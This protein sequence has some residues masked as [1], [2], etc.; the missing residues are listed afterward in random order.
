MNSKFIYWCAFI[1]LVFL[2]LPVTTLA[3]DNPVGV[4][5]RGHIQDVGDYPADGS[6]VDSPAI[7]GTEG[8]S[9]RIEGFEIKLTGE[10]PAGMEMRYNVHVQNKG[11]LYDENDSA[12][13]PKDGDYAGTRGESLRI[14]A[15]KIVLTDS[16]GKPVPG[17]SVQ[18][19]GHVQNVGDLPADESQWIKDGD[20]LGTVGSSLRLEALLVKV[21]KNQT[22]LTAYQALLT[23]IGK[24]AETDYTAASWGT[25]QKALTDNAVTAD[26]SQL[27]VNKAT[28]A[29]QKAVDGLAKKAAAVVYDTAGTY[30]PET[31]TEVIDGDV[32]VKADGITLRNLHINGDLTIGADQVAEKTEESAADTIN[33]DQITQETTGSIT[34]ELENLYI[35]YFTR[36]SAGTGVGISGSP[37]QAFSF[38]L[39]GG[40]QFTATT[41]GGGT[42]TGAPMQITAGSSGGSP[43]GV[44]IGGAIGSLSLQTPGTQLSLAPGCQVQLLSLQSGALNCGI[45][46]PPTA[47]IQSAVVQAPGAI[48]SGPG[49]IQHADIRANGAIFATRP[50]AFTVAPGV[51]AQPSMPAPPNSGGDGGGGGYTPT[52]SQPVISP[53]G[54]VAFP[55]TVTISSQ[56][57]DAIYYTT[58]GSN[59]T[60]AGAQNTTKVVGG[61]AE[62][63]VTSNI[64]LKVVA[65]RSGYYDSA[66]ASATFT[67][68]AS[69]DLTGI[70]LSTTT[71]NFTFTP[72]TY[73]YPS[74]TVPYDTQSI[75]I[76]PSGSGSITVDGKTTANGMPSE[77]IVVSFKVEKIIEVVTKEQ[78][79]A[80]KTYTIKVTP[81]VGSFTPSQNPVTFSPT[82][83]AMTFPAT[84]ALSSIEAEAI[85][86]TTDGSD[87]STVAGATNTIVKTGTTATIT[88]D[89]AMTVK[90]IAT[91]AG[92]LNSGV[93]S[94]TYTLPASADLTGIGLNVPA[95]NFVFSATTYN[96]PNVTVA[97]DVEGITVTPSGSGVIKVADTTVASGASLTIPVSYK[98]ETTITIVNQ[99]Q[100]KTA[101]TYT[102]KV[103]P[104]SGVVIPKVTTQN[105]TFTATTTSLDLNTSGIFGIKPGTSGVLSNVVF[106]SNNTS[107]I[108]S[109][110]T[111]D[112][113]IPILKDGTVTLT[114]ATASVILGESTY[115][116]ISLN[117]VVIVVRSSANLA[118]VNSGTG[119]VDDYAKAGITGVVA[120][121]LSGINHAVAAARTAASGVDLDQTAIQNLVAG[122]LDGANNFT[123]ALEK[124]YSKMQNDAFNL[125]ITN[126][127]DSY[128]N[129]LSG[130]KDIA[131]TLTSNQ[132]DLNCGTKVT[133]ANGTATV[134]LSLSQIGAH[135]L[136]VAINGGSASPILPVTVY[137]KLSFSSAN[138]VSGYA[139]ANGPVVVIPPDNQ[140]TP[141]TAIGDGVFAKTDIELWDVNV[142]SITAVTIPASVT[143][144]G[145]S[146]FK[147][148][149]NLTTVTFTGTS[150]LQ[151]IGANAFNSCWTLTP[152]EIPAS[153]TTIGDGAFNVCSAFST[154]TFA[155]DSQLS[156]IGE[157][158]FQGCK[159]T[160]IHIPE[161][162]E[163][164]GINAFDGCSTLTNVTFAENSNLLTIG[165]SAFFNCSLTTIQIPAKVTTIG[166]NAFHNNALTGTLTIPNSVT[167][168]G[169]DAFSINNLTEL[170][171]QGDGNLVIMEGAFNPSSEEKN[172][173]ISKITIPAG[174]TIDS[175]ANTMGK[176][177]GG[178]ITAYTAGGA[179]TYTYNPNTSIWSK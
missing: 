134:P 90:A 31:G 129:L 173:P 128:G 3:A 10:I 27:E 110:Y 98:T 122:Y 126:A 48:F 5:Y 166:T 153:V 20:Q 102:I 170:L 44:S 135:T 70:A 177:D 68:A 14:E 7:I 94:A 139:A 40:T 164:I 119:T 24:S 95:E 174:V 80:P 76:T 107:M 108:A 151:T 51:T 34:T 159:M 8:Q 114:F 45:L 50:G 6:W 103:T 79:K 15:V 64:T 49:A 136:T 140:G 61:S 133:F 58:D 12:N 4:A 30:G 176:N 11:W 32:I 55:T 144:I 146:A 33:A 66:I 9:K 65:T 112:G 92:Y 86:Y 13:W 87:P 53:S 46:T 69:A 25:L 47:V 54:A 141:V 35:E 148:C 96:Y 73:N 62:I 171:I 167:S 123:L 97:N 84:V 160:T 36:L 152:F 28:T 161:K 78:G 116:N 163:T 23:A 125:S 175:T 120:G 149:K 154:V 89:Q 91:R 111:G 113:K 19:R 132:S 145:A 67:Q 17:Y 88:I 74:V 130:V 127:K 104:S 178:L 56:G 52:Q 85:Y 179:G 172:N 39:P 77:P 82:D 71:D 169:A 156:T 147:N 150:A 63:S 157:G 131:I 137:S 2:C 38:S 41:P 37:S 158:A 21:T 60:T 83:G 138:T 105:T 42:G 117:N 93:T 18:Y 81:G 75:N 168:I 106:A 26:N 99:E 118:K 29:I 165:K 43:G 115:N 22:D 16:D 57:A 155:A 101:K 142:T 124:N 72:A 109:G 1:T 162:L 143:A 59:P 121:N 100:G